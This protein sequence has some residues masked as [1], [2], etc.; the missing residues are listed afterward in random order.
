MYIFFK[1]QGQVLGNLTKNAESQVQE[2]I[3]YCGRLDPMAS[4]IVLYIPKTTNQQKFMKMNKSYKFN[5]IFGI[6]TDSADCLGK[7]LHYQPTN[8]INISHFLSTINLFSG[9]SYK[10]KYPPFSAY[11]IKKNGLKK[12]LWYFA[13]RGELEECD[14]PEHEVSVYFL[15]MD[16]KPMFM[17][18][19]CEYFL[20]QLGRLEDG[21]D[22]RKDEVMEGFM[23]VENMRL[24]G[25]PMVAKVSSGTYIR[26]LCEDIG[27]K[28]GMYCI[29]DKI[30]RIG[31]TNAD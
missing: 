17:V 7:I 19:G 28:M 27:E 22:L 20:E 26:K 21:L 1:Q 5:I 14:I 9:K 4:G 6:K 3:Q 29:A 2:K 11:Y 23:G 25:I 16:V 8:T 31:Y 13:R 30:E 24:V 15:D 18:R 12:P 10:Q